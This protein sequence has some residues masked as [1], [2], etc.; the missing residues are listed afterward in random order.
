VAV[1][2]WEEEPAT[3]A[4]EVRR[5]HADNKASWEQAAEV[6]ATEHD[7]TLAF[8]GDGGSN[9]HPIE[10]EI[11]ESHRGPLSRWCEV[12]IHLQCASGKDTL[13]LWNEGAQRVVGVDIAERHVANARRLSDELG[14]PADWYRCDVLDTP[15]ELDGTADL[16]YT[17]RGAIGWMHDL[18][19][20]AAVIARLLRPH[21]VLSLFD[22]H[23]AS[24]LFD[25]DEEEIVYSG[26]R[27]FDSAG[28]GHGFSESYISHLGIPAD[29]VLVNHDR[30]WTLADIYAAVAGAGLE[31]VALGEHPEQYWNAFPAW[32]PAQVARIPQTFSVI[33]RAR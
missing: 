15:R 11:L 20:W 4:E 14:A 3:T 7:E 13:S 31:V 32:E 1:E 9:L 22:D 5:R 10:R 29:E 17:G 12:A 23:P 26:V 33:A 25:P 28:A 6:Y 8:L 18:D 2:W 21:G 19:A 27:Y 30:L 24:F 16:V